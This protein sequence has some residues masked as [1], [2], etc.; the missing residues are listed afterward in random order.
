[1][2]HAPFVCGFQRVRN[3]LSDLQ[4]FARSNRP[5]LQ[6]I[7]ER[8]AFNQLQDEVPE[9]VRFFEIIDRRDIRMIQ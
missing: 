5:A 4:C 3:L 7:C 8:L 6:S 1:M 2:D 9:T